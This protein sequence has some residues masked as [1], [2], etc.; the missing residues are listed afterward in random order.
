M[1]KRQ[2]N[3]IK[4]TNSLV[5]HLGINSIT[6][7]VLRTVCFVFGMFKNDVEV[8]KRKVSKAQNIAY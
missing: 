1:K 6:L 7:I 8:K 4:F 3:V 2:K 5:K